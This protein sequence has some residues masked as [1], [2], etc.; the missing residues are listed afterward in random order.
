VT[1]RAMHLVVALGLATL[2]TGVAQALTAS[3]D[4]CDE[5]C[6][7][8]L[9]GKG[10][11]PNCSLGTCAK[12]KPAIDSALPEV[13]Q[14]APERRLVASVAGVQPVLPLVTSGVFHPPRS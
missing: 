14:A 9:G 2:S 10:C 13:A 5:H 12:V 6:E 7:A 4:C 8:T 3:D 1:R 11:P